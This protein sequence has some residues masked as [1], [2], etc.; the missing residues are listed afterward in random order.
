MFTLPLLYVL[1]WPY[2]GH[3][4]SVLNFEGIFLPIIGDTLFFASLFV[5]GGDFWDK[6]RVLF[7]HSAKVTIEP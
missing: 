5:L 3:A 2:L 6:L 7:V 4:V 1:I